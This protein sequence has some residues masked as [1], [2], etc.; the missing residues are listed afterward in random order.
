MLPAKHQKDNIHTSLFRSDVLKRWKGRLNKTSLQILSSSLATNLLKYFLFG[1]PSASFSSLERVK[2]VFHRSQIRFDIH[3]HC[4]V[5][6]QITLESDQVYILVWNLTRVA[7]TNRELS[8]SFRKPCQFRPLPHLHVHLTFLPAWPFTFPDLS[9]RFYL[10]PSLNSGLTSLPQHPTT[11]HLCHSSGPH[12][13]P[14][15]HLSHL[16]HTHFSSHL[17]D[18]D[19]CL[20]LPHFPYCQRQDRRNFRILSKSKKALGKAAQHRILSQRVKVV[21]WL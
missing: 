1:L 12:H 15:V 13:P 14:S 21:P 17:T 20:P 18:A 4:L 19:L 7:K 3:H 10:S 8:A 2:R 6:V 5:T 9:R 16:C 11:P